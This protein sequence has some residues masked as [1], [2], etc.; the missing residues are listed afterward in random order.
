MA[1][2]TRQLLREI[3]DRTGLSMDAFAKAIG[4]KGQSS[5]QRYES[6]AGYERRKFLTP[7]MAMKI[8]EAFVG[9]GQPPIT[10]A[11]VR[12]LAGLTLLETPPAKVEDPP[13]PPGEHMTE[14]P[15]LRLPDLPLDVPVRG[16]AVGGN[17]G[18]FSL[19]GETVDYIRRPPVLANVRSA[20]AIFY[21][22]DSMY[23]AFE[24]GDPIYINPVRPPRA[25]DYV[26]IEMHGGRD[27]SPGAAYVKKLVR[28]TPTQIIVAQFNP[29][30]DDI[31]FPADKVRN[32][33]RIVPTKELLGI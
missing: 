27:G 6:E 26:L 1:K 17:A 18:D 22:N 7:E 3:R 14:A 28:R 24:H 33:W 20:F 16:T 8:G 5:Y 2:T 19:N 21:T 9:K 30:R 25:G 10:D 12:Q 23:P 32:L 15:M 29:V 31:Q 13:L 4:L 11:E